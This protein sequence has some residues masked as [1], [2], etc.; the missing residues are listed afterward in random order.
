[1]NLLFFTHAVPFSTLRDLWSG[2]Q[3]PPNDIFHEGIGSLIFFAIWVAVAWLQL[4]RERRTIASPRR[5]QKAD[6]LP[7]HRTGGQE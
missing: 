2:E 3:V 7:C 4:E 1:M 5:V 6:A